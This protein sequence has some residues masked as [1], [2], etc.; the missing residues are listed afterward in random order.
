MSLGIADLPHGAPKPAVVCGGEEHG[1][2]ITT[3]ELRA[4]YTGT[5]GVARSSWMFVIGAV[6]EPW[7]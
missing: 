3:E 6:D 2:H 5:I 1:V 7:L 4:S